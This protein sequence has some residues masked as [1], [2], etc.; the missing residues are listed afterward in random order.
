MYN[1]ELVIITTTILYNKRGPIIL[2]NFHDY[3]YTQTYCSE[4]IAMKQKYQ[5][6]SLL[7]P[8]IINTH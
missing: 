3:K 8:K 4:N 6:K 7:I 1:K 5:Y 2:Y